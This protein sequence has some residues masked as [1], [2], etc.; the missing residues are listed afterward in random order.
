MTK[1]LAHFSRITECDKSHGKLYKGP[2]AI[3]TFTGELMKAFF[4]RSERLLK[5]QSFEKKRQPSQWWKDFGL[6]FLVLSN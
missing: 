4:S 6:F 2:Q 3:V 5:T 1:D